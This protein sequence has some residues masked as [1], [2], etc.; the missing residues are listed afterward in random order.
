MRF[1]K[2]ILAVSFLAVLILFTPNLLTQ[3]SA[4]IPEDSR[5]PRLNYGPKSIAA[6]EKVMVS[7]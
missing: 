6:G 4:N 5:D 2:L 3:S 1:A 7:T